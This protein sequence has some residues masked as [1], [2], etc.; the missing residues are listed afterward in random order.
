MQEIKIG[1]AREK[2]ILN[3]KFLFTNIDFFQKEEFFSHCTEKFINLE[4]CGN[5]DI[6]ID[7]KNKKYIRI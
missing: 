1:V 7:T 5:R 4:D 6:E 3:A 2:I